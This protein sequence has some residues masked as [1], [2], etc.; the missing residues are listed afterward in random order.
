MYIFPGTIWV[1]SDDKNV[2]VLVR[3]KGKGQG[4][5]CETHI[6]DTIITE[7]TPL[8]PEEKPPSSELLSAYFT[9]MVEEKLLNGG[10]LEEYRLDP[11]VILPQIRKD[12]DLKRQ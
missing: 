3:P 11:K 2:V 1:E 5:V 10:I 6:R 9:V 12:F 8:E 4:A 7:L